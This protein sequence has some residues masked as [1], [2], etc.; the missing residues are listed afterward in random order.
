MRA[1]PCPESVG[2]AQEI[3]LVDGVEYLDDGPLENLV[4]Q[5]GDAERPL[6]PVRLRDIRPARWLSPVAPA[7]QSRVQ[8]PEVGLQLLPVGLPGHPVHPRRRRR[9]NRP[10]GGPQPVEIDMVQQRGEPCLLVLSCYLAHT[11]QRTG[12]ALPGS[13]SGT[14]FAG[15]VP[16]GHAPFLPHLRSQSVVRRVRRYYGHV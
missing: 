2:E 5:R 15:R 12:R 8:V 13:V 11:S 14:R 10:V 4:L 9:T 16:L 3:H 6:P 1:T 7:V